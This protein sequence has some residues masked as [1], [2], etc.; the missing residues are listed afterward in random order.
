MQSEY[1][2][3]KIYLSIFL[4]IYSWIP[5]LEKSKIS[6]LWGPKVI[7]YFVSKIG[8]LILFYLHF[9]MFS[10]SFLRSETLWS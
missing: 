5:I 2:K 8:S 4:S 1:I 9:V 7:Q 6:A 10:F 3:H